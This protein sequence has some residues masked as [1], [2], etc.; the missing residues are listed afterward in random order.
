M[1]FVGGEL[2]DVGDDGVEEGLGALSAMASEGVDQA[3]FA[4][5][6]AGFVEGFGDAVGV[7]GESVPGAEGALADFA[8]PFFENAE[9]GGGGVEAIDRIVAAENECGQMAAVNVADKATRDVVIGEEERGEGAVGRVL[10][11]ELIDGA[12]EALRLIERNSALA[13]EIGLQ[14][15]HQQRGGDPFAGNVAD[16]ET[17]PAGA[18][19]EEIVIIAADG[20]RGKAVAGI[21]ERGNWRTD[22]RKKAALNFVG[23]FEFLG[24]AS[25]GFEFCS[26]GAALGFEGV[27]DLVE[28]HESEGVAVDVTEAGDDAAPNG[29]LRAEN[30]RI[31][32]R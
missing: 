25:F 30:G 14:I 6:V 26:G 17:E 28:A 12:Q 21:V 5:F 32:L 31:G 27:S 16:D 23:D 20:A 10:G 29:G 13:A 19:I 24:G 4:E 11:K 18:E 2:P 7:E 8:I 1:L 15:G 9:D 22:L 3:G